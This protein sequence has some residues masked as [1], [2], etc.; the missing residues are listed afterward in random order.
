MHKR[1]KLYIWIGMGCVVLLLA[2]GAVFSQLQNKPNQT[3][4][5]TAKTTVSSSQAKAE[6]V[7]VQIKLPGAT[8]I[9]ALVDDY[10]LPTSLWTVVSKDYP[11]SEPQYRPSNLELTDLPARSDKSADEKS[12][13]A[14]IVPDLTSLFNAAK[15]AGHDIMIASGFRSYDLQQ[16][17]FSSYSQNYGEEA[18]N[19]FSA[20]PGQSEHQTGL[21]LDIAYSNRDCYLDV[22]FGTK[23][24][25]E[26]LAANAY[27][28]GFVLRY[29]ADKTAVTKY[30]YE[31]WHFRYVGKPLAIA[32][33]ESGL[34]LDEARPYLQTAL[35]ELK[36]QHK[37]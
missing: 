15:S 35:T 7:K 31:P 5:S 29:P 36:A 12:V 21:A 16:T 23:P 25:G 26:W 27:T 33:H 20:R 18:A 11:L 37:I 24:A 8:P 10:N 30:Q 14:V 3:S 28:Y 4:P 34:T 13:R 9:D 1:T 2:G 17:Y 22:C 6:T 19:K 32:L